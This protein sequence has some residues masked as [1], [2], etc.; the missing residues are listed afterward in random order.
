MLVIR[1]AVGTL[2]AVKVTHSHLNDISH[3]ENTFTLTMGSDHSV[4]VLK[5]VYSV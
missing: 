1:E 2:V 4:T 3:S 5:M